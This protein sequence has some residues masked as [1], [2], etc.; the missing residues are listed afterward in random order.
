MVSIQTPQHHQTPP[1]GVVSFISS[2]W[3]G[4]VSDKYLTE[5]SGL[6]DKLLPGD[7]VLADRVFNIAEV[8][9]LKQAEIY[10]P[11]FTKGKGQLSA[12]EVEETRSI[13][14]VRIHVEGNCCCQAGVSHFT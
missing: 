3:G 5:H 9:G 4:R 11:A 1:Q 10:P 7:V 6:L 12:L 14:N 8:V 2:A 13:A